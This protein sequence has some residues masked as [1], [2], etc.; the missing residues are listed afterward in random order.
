MG[1]FNS[2]LNTDEDKIINVKGESEEYIQT[3]N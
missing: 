1:R 2:R 3:E